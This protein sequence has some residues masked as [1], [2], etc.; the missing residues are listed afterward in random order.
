M[1]K[2]GVFLV[3]ILFLG[4]T[5][6]ASQPVPG[7]KFEFSTAFSFSNFKF[8]GDADSTTVWSLPL[9]VGYFVW[10]GLEIEPEV[11]LLKFSHEDASYNM[12]GNLSYNFNASGQL[13]LFLLAGAGFGNGITVG[14]IVEGSTSTNAT[15]LNFGGGVK[16]VIGNS[17]AFRVEYR[18]TRNRLSKGDLEPATV[19][20][21]QFFIGVSLFF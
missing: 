13:K 14:P 6:A 10:K 19:N 1:K 4:V 20:L 7:K 2:L 17:G 5:F 21:H 11:I 9:R 15:L 18:F 8:S 12:N 3:A 16:Y